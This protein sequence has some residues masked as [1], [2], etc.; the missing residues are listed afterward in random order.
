[1]PRPRLQDLLGRLDAVAPGHLDVDD[2]DVG[3]QLFDDVDDVAAVRRLADDLDAVGIGHPRLDRLTHDLMVVTEN[4]P[5]CVP[6]SSAHSGPIL[7]GTPYGCKILG[8]VKLPS[9]SWRF[10]IRAMIVRP[11]A[12]AVPFRVWTGC[13]EAPSW[14]R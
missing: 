4:D 14:G 1:R 5:L 11:T 6:H 13:G 7:A 12:Q 2:E 9:L 10:S 3:L 8:S